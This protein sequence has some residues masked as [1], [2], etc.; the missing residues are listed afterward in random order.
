MVTKS[1]SSGTPEKS[2]EKIKI[3]VLTGATKHVAYKSPRE[4]VESENKASIT[5]DTEDDREHLDAVFGPLNPVMES[6]RLLDSWVLS[7]REFLLFVETGMCGFLSTCIQRSTIDSSALLPEPSTAP[8]YEW[9][10]ARE[11]QPPQAGGAP[12]PGGGGS[13]ARRQDS[14]QGTG[15]EGSAFSLGDTESAE[16]GGPGHGQRVKSKSRR[17]QLTVTAIPRHKEVNTDKQLSHEDH[18]EPASFLHSRGC[19]VTGR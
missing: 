10:G 4:C 16:R 14:R 2:S 6:G 7:R 19:W 9:E 15:S 3:L 12:I 17:R 1:V 13:Q 8:T 18:R 5:E 11:R